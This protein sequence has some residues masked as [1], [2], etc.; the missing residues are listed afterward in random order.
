MN[1]YKQNCYY[2]V[3]SFLFEWNERKLVNLPRIVVYL[4]GLRF[5]K[6]GGDNSHFMWVS[7]SVW[8]R[9]S[10]VLGSSFCSVQLSLSRLLVRLSCVYV[11]MFLSHETTSNDTV[12]SF[13][14][15]YMIT[16]SYSSVVPC[17]EMKMFFEKGIETQAFLWYQ[18]LDLQKIIHKIT[19]LLFLK[20]W[21]QM[22]HVCYMSISRSKWYT[23]KD[24]NKHTI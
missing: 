5:K 1:I 6:E 24:I 14:T 15:I 22:I 17:E 19:L 16:I 23:W 18:L 21:F 20:C 4:I 12:S 13:Y 11:R 8:K 9:R 10:V 7:M 3:S 2:L